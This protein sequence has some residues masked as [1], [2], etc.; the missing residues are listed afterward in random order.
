M[1]LSLMLSKL[2]RSLEARRAVRLLAMCS[3]RELSDLGLT[4]GQIGSA[5]L[6]RPRPEL[7]A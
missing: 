4:R 1:L 6:V 5:V 7:S 2:Q 3:D